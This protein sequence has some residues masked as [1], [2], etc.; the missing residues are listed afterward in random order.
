MRTKKQSK[1]KNDNKK[2]KKVTHGLRFETQILGLHEGQLVKEITDHVIA[3]KQK[4]AKKLKQSRCPAQSENAVAKHPH[5]DPGPVEASGIVTT[6]VA[7]G[8]NH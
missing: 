6:E 7:D 3:W 8:L 4:V 1:R 2:T 5:P